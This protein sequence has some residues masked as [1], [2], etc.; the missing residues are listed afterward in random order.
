MPVILVVFHRGVRQAHWRHNVPPHH[1]LDE[2]A[3]VGELV[4]VGKFG[5]SVG[6]YDVV[7]LPLRSLLAVWMHGR[8]EEES[9]HHSL[10]LRRGEKRRI[11]WKSGLG[12]LPLTVSVLATANFRECR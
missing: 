6:P 5:E 4:V 1:L 7:K 9:L 12:Y 3:H 10:C 11:S 8:G 2:G